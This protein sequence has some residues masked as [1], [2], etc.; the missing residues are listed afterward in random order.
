MSKLSAPFVMKVKFYAPTGKNQNKN[1]AHVRYIGTRSG[2]DRSDTQWDLNEDEFDLKEISPDSPAGHAK[3]ANERPGS[4]GL[5]S[6]DPYTKPDMK[7]IQNE[8]VKHEG[9]VW[10]MILSLKE[11][12]AQIL[13]YTGKRQWEQMLRSTVIDAAEKM[14]IKPTNVKWV[15]AFHEEKGHPHVHLIMWEK[16]P[17]R[18]RG[19][20]SK[21]EFTDVRKTFV[22]QIYAEERT[23]L[24]QEQTSIRDYI[25]DIVK[26]EVFDS[27]KILQNLENSDLV[28]DLKSYGQTIDT[29][30]SPRLHEED[31]KTLAMKL[32]NLSEGMPDKGRIAFKYMPED[33]RKETLLITD[34]LLERPQFKPLVENF[35]GHAEE[36]ASHHSFKPEDLQKSRKNAY[37]EIQKR[38]AQL[39]LRG[40]AEARNKFEFQPNMKLTEAIKPFLDNAISNQSMNPEQIQK[41]IKTFTR[42]LLV[43]GHSKEEA[44]QVLQKWVQSSKLNIEVSDLE[45]SI[46]KAIAFREERQAWGKDIV[47]SPNEWKRFFSD[48]GVS[49][50]SV[51]KWMWSKEK[52]HSNAVAHTV[53]KGAWKALEREQQKTEARAIMERRKQAQEAQLTPEQKQRRRAKEQSQERDDD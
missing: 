28:L 48:I 36:I 51:P 16:D 42:I 23:R 25:R 6:Q 33:V 30:I 50:K 19:V 4:H 27:V 18:D 29:S 46:D 49:E 14:Q 34:W 53:V 43:S 3:Y 52:G 5:F 26:D 20:L 17:K 41:D 15:A 8:L 37:Q 12:D 24:F 11:E 21:G 7:E 44:L 2:A 39:V 32:H 31:N 13:G 9:I 38:M 10:R 1:A 35:L 40:A 47:I 45:K 22:N